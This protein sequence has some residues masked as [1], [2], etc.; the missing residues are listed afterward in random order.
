[1]P[2]FETY[3]NFKFRRD[4]TD[5]TKINPDSANTNMRNTGIIKRA[6]NIPTLR[7]V[8]TNRHFEDIIML[9]VFKNKTYIPGTK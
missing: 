4:L 8:L 2:Y 1:M 6:Y 7:F 9:T 3:A 5:N